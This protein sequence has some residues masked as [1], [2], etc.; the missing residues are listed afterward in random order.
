MADVTKSAWAQL[1]VPVYPVLHLCANALGERPQSGSSVSGY[2]VSLP[3]R[4]HDSVGT[5]TG[6][7]VGWGTS[8]G[9]GSRTRHPRPATGPCPTSSRCWSCENEFSCAQ[10][11]ADIDGRRSGRDRATAV[12]V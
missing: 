12:A 9:S 5:L 6:G 8:G 11:G 3:S 4:R 10:A 1:M 2:R 7:A